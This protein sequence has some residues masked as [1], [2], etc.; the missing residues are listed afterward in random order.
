[1]VKRQTSV[2][3]IDAITDKAQNLTIVTGTGP[4]TA[5][6]LID[7]VQQYYAGEVTRFILWDLTKAT[8]S[9]IS[10]EEVEAHAKSF[11]RLT[12][13]RQGGRSAFVFDSD[14]EYGLGRMYQALSEIENVPIEFQTFRDIDEARQWLGLDDAGTALAGADEA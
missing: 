7:W 3:S 6:E 1:L 2:G 11:N 4:L 14:L 5:D 10:F 13:P 12:G 9:A 8:L